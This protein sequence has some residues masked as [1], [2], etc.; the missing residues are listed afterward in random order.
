M[1]LKL[2]SDLLPTASDVLPKSPKSIRLPQPA[3]ASR[4]GLHTRITKATVGKLTCPPGQKE[5]SPGPICGLCR[6]R[7][8]SSKAA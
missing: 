7:L 4:A 6:P 1:P 2:A 3:K 8:P 5:A